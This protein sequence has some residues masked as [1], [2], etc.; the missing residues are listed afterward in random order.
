MILQKEQ[1]LRKRIEEEEREAQSQSDERK[2]LLEAYKHK[3]AQ[4]QPS[5]NTTPAKEVP[6][7]KDNSSSGMTGLVIGIAAVSIIDAV[8]MKLTRS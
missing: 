6:K 1:E 8:V 3:Q 2:R 4:D 5:T 7:K